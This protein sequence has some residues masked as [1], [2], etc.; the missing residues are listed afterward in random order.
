MKLKAGMVAGPE[1]VLSMSVCDIYARAPL[2]MYI[3]MSKEKKMGH[4]AL[5]PYMIR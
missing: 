5:V 2:L 3:H 1:G 4:H